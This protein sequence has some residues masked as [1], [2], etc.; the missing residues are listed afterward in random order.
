[1]SQTALTQSEAHAKINQINDAMA[2]AH[3]CVQNMQ[4]HSQQMTTTSWQG[5]Q[6]QQFG[7]RMQ[8][9]TDDMNAVVNRLQQVAE[10]GKSNMQA[11][12]NLDSE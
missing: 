8:Q 7:I 2:S 1:M 4:D 5:N 10:T 6:A 11:M 9:F 12:A 3:K